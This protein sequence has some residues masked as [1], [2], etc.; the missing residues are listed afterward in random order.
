MLKLGL[1]GKGISRSQSARLHVLLG[2]MC[3]MDVSYDYL[4]SD[5]IED[6][7]LIKQLTTCSEKG[8]AGVNVTHPYKT[9]ARKLITPR[10]RLPAAL[11]AVNTVVFREDGWRGD[12]TDFVGFM[13]GYK[14]QFGDAKP[15]TVLQLGAGGVGLATAFGL[16]G[17]GANKIL[18][19]DK[20]ITRGEELVATLTAADAQAEFVSAENLSDAVRSADGLIN[21]T[22]VGMNQYPGCPFDVDLL[23]G[24]KWAFD[25]VYTPVE[26]AFLRTATKSGIEVMTGF[27]L[28]FFQGIEAFEVFSGAEIDAD[29]A[30][31]DY[32][33]VYP[34]ALTG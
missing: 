15:G 4:D 1:I 32:F 12:N 28:F 17:L 26:T 18:V 27:E 33:N 22:P 5:Q 24:Q 9:S 6:F 7:D 14:Q 13:R 20:D 29:A 2:R 10:K 3:G 30:R 34:E 11:G 8:Y 25:A 19:H 21:C 31:Q 16:R 23:G